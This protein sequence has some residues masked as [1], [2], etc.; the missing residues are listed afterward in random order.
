MSVTL[1]GDREIRL[2]LA[3]LQQ[4]TSLAMAKAIAL[5][6][7]RVEAT[8]KELCPKDTEALAKSIGTEMVMTPDSVTAKVGPTEDIEYGKYVEYGTGIYAV[9]GVGRKTPWVYFNQRLGKY[10]TTKG[11]KPRPFLFNSLRKHKAWINKAMIYAISD[12]WGKVKGMR[13]TNK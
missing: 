13:W 7:A 11:M 2:E 9:G 4:V 10:F 3:S 5:S 6:A 8:A 12:G 1:K